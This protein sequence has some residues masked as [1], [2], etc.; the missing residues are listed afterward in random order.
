MKTAEGTC[1]ASLQTILLA[2]GWPPF[3]RPLGHAW[4]RQS[5]ATDAVGA[6]SLLRAKCVA[7]AQ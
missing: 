1:V 2:T 5:T 3:A 6:G 7:L 4:H